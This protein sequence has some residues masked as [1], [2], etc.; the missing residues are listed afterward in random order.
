DLAP[1]VQFGSGNSASI[2]LSGD[3]GVAG[4]NQLGND[5]NAIINVDG[6]DAS[7]SVFQNGD[8]NAADLLVSSSGASGALI[9]IGNDNNTR[10]SVSG[11]ANASVSFTLEGNGV[12]TTVP[13]TV[14]SIGGGQ[15]T[16]IQRQL[17]TFTTP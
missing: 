4:L 3:G 10:L 17:N 8:R 15:V 11:S 7:G 1:A 5:N 2:T 12:T 16:I 13:A 9:Q 6:L 14:S